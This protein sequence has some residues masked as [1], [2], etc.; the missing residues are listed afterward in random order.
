MEEFRRLAKQVADTTAE[1]SRLKYAMNLARMK[2]FVDVPPNISLI[3]I[4]CGNAQWMIRYKCV[5][6]SYSANLYLHESEYTS[7][8][9]ARTVFRVKFGYKNG[10]YFIKLKNASTS[11][12]YKDSRIIVYCSTKNEMLRI[13]N[14][15]YQYELDF[16]EQRELIDRYK[17]SDVPEAFALCVFDA[18]GPIDVADMCETLLGEYHDT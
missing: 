4:E 12:T 3:H 2:L 18:I 6:A 11:D 9:V 10:R 17:C 15:D 8:V 7:G 13:I 1:L 16:D 14:N 5:A